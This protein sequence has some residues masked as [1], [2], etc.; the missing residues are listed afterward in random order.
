[1]ILRAFLRQLKIPLPTKKAKAI[2]NSIGQD[3]PLS[4]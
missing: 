1:M 2:Q 4:P 3:R